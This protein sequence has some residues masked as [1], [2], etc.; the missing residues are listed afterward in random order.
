[1]GVAFTTTYVKSLTFNPNGGSG[2]GTW[3]AIAGQTIT[4]PAAATRAGYTGGAW[5]GVPY[6]MPNSSPTYWTSWTANTNTVYKVNHMKLNV[7]QDNWDL[8]EQETL[9]GTTDTS[10]TASHKAYTGFYA[11]TDGGGS[12]SGTINGNGSTVLTQYYRRN[13]YNIT[14]NADGGTG[15][16]AATSMIYGGAL[17]AP[18]PGTKTG[19]T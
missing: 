3:D 11:S 5:A 13:F 9:Y 8:A 6:R 15:G 19:Y 2:G 16:A 18:S 4:A 7:A 12:D 17:S 14:F 1:M 10:V